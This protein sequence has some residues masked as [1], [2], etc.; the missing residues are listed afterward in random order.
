MAILEKNE[1]SAYLCEYFR[2]RFYNRSSI[3]CLQHLC[4]KCRFGHYCEHCGY[5]GICSDEDERAPK[6]TIRREDDVQKSVDGEG[7]E[8]QG[9]RPAGDDR[10][11]DERAVQAAREGSEGAGLLGERESHTIPADLRRVYKRVSLKSFVYL[12]EFVGTGDK[13]EERWYHVPAG[14]LHKLSDLGDG[15]IYGR[16]YLGK[17]LTFI[18]RLTVYRFRVVAADLVLDTKLCQELLEQWNA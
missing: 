4:E 5:H 17:D 12:S 7:Q 13:K 9:Q 18:Y 14:D 11:G 3:N 15:K 10:E 1:H 8:V 16:R 6:Q 2:C